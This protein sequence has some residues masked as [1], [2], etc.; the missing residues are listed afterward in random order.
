MPFGSGFMIEYGVSGRKIRRFRLPEWQDTPPPERKYGG[1]ANAQSNWN[2]LLAI[3]SIRSTQSPQPTAHRPPVQPTPGQESPS[4]AGAPA[5]HKAPRPRR[6]GA[7]A[8]A[9]SGRG[10]GNKQ[11]GGTTARESE[12]R[13][14]LKI[15]RPLR[16]PRPFAAAAAPFPS[17]YYPSPR[18][19]SPCQRARAPTPSSRARPL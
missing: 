11:L 13:Q 14:N 7:A 16:P 9:V 19:R 10:K 3:S 18:P 17:P 4:L 1:S 15:N 6:A 5:T 8:T 12:W 2:P